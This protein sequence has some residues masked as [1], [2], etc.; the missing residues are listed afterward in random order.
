MGIELAPLHVPLERRL[1][2]MG[3]I[4]HF[5]FVFL[6]PVLPILLFLW[7]ALRGYFIMILA[8]MGWM[9]W[10]S[11][12]PRRGAYASRFLRNLRIHRW[13]C[14]FFPLKFHA[15]APLPND[16]NYLIGLHPHGII[17]VSVYNFFG[18]GSGTMDLFPNINFHICTLVSQF[19]F[20]LRREWALLHGMIEAS[21]DSLRYTLGGSSKGQ[22]AVIVVGGAEEA[23]DAHPGK[24]VLTLK[25]RKGFIR[26]ALE[27]GAHLVPCFGFGENNLYVQ[28]ANGQGTLLR[29]I[30]TWFKKVAGFSPPLFY[31]RGI[32]NYNFGLLPFRHELHTVLGAPIPVEKTESPTNEQVDALHALYI[33]K[34]TELFE[35]HKTK[36]GVD[37][38]NHLIIH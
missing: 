34:L 26:M 32:F 23:L 12:S 35:E 17:C 14:D 10:D 1:Q 21:K 15:N 24:Y 36:F 4:Y 5:F 33:Q 13:L 2:T 19:Y 28:A 25:P 37:E 38:D 29:R 22:A 8:Y 31:G 7:L 16:K 9:W 11:D 18:N 20:P 3:A 6:M 30:Q 27:T